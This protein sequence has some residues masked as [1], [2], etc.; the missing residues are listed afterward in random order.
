MTLVTWFDFDGSR[1]VT[2]F[3]REEEAEIFAEYLGVQGL[4]RVKDDKLNRTEGRY[5]QETATHDARAL[6]NEL[7]TRLSQN[8]PL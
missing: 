4:W 6:A 8:L 2:Q 3:D 1:V 5:G 7:Q